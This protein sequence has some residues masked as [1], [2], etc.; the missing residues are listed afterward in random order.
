[1]M[2]MMMMT[3]TM[4]MTTMMPLFWRDKPNGCQPLP[5]CNTPKMVLCKTSYRDHDDLFHALHT[6]GIEWVEWDRVVLEDLSGGLKSLSGVLKSL[7]RVC[8]GMC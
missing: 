7:S 2:M 8:Q 6:H 1:M 4:M 3:M 5:L